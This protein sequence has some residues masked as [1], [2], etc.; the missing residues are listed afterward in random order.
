MLSSSELL[1]ESF[2]NFVSD[3]KSFLVD[4]LNRGFI[5]KD[6]LNKKKIELCIKHKL[7]SIPNDIQI[8]MS[9]DK[10]DIERFNSVLSVKPGRE[11]SGVSV[12]AVMTKPL[13]CPGKCIYCPGG[14]NSFYGD[15]PKSYTGKEPAARRAAR[16]H[17]DSYLQVFNRLEHYVVSGHMPQKI[18]LI[19]MGAT[20]PAFSLDYQ[21]SFIYYAFKAMNDFSQMFFKGNGFDFKYFKDFFELP[22]DIN[23]S[24]RTKRI[25]S[26][27]LDLKKKH[28][29][30]LLIEHSI[31]QK[32]NVRCVGLTIETR[33]DYA[34]LSIANE[35]LLLGATRIELG[36]QSVYDDVLDFVKRGHSVKDTVDATAV[37]K[38]LGF[39]INYHMMPGLPTVSKQRDIDGLKELFDNPD[40]RP[41]MLK[42]YPCMV[43]PGTELYSLY[44]S[45]D[46]VPLSTDAAAE[47][48]S[49][50][51]R[52]V[53]RYVRI[54]RVQR[55]I[56]SNLVFAGV[57]KTNLRQF[58]LKKLKQKNIVCNCIRCREI[59]NEKIN[60]IELNVIEYVASKGKEF[61]I[62]LDEFGSDKLIGFCRLR[63]PHK[64]LRAEFTKT[65]AVIRELHVY[66]RAELLG[67]TGVVQHRGFGKMLLKK[68]E[69]IAKSQGY[70]KL[71]V[72]SGVGVRDYY[73][74]Q[75]YVLEGPYMSKRLS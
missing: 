44:K 57:D 60:R 55:D 1:D 9:F 20:F 8:L 39:K 28:V 36:V 49:E 47:I 4:S 30:P 41:D 32:S 10:K 68:A 17:F 31:N 74:S 67:E 19:V 64:Q 33:P 66:G 62:S 65:T 54:M 11:M 21:R 38:D 71:L 46:F 14:V 70:D 53:P 24:E 48:I 37:L 69:D 73:A 50:F 61:F 3:L 29:R 72:I 16:N 12:V 2:H 45:G 7:K 51:K 75:G 22:A 52:Y 13:A 40:F 25:H 18:E 27:L 34:T 23:D 26:K 5:D 58:V 43:M 63:F 59:K 42:I 56:P 35:L 15:T 6:V